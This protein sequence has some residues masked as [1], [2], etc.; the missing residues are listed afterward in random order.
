[1]NSVRAE[2]RVCRAR[3]IH[4]ADVR[5]QNET[6]DIGCEPGDADKTNLL[7]R[8]R[9]ALRIREKQAHGTQKRFLTDHSQ[10]AYVPLKSR[11]AGALSRESRTH[12]Q[13]LLPEYV[14]PSGFVVQRVLPLLPGGKIDRC[15]LPDPDVCRPELSRPYVAPTSTTG[16]KTANLWREALQSNRLGVDEHFFDLGGYSLLFVQI[17]RD[18]DRL[19]RRE[20]CVTDM[21]RV[22]IFAA[23]QFIGVANRVDI[24]RA[25]PLTESMSEHAAAMRARTP[26]R[27][28]GLA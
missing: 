2:L 9:P 19:V 21:F 15:S 14:V 11:A 28:G 24:S 23:R 8:Y 12:L 5:V 25:K 7:F 1:M 18:L 13:H 22:R 26:V 17:H 27:H 20:L 10:L 16:E 4:P 6:W 3:A